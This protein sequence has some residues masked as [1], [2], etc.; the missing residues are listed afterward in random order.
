M[1]RQ[2]DNVEIQGQQP[3][4]IFYTVVHSVR[5]VC[6]F[7]KGLV[8]YLRIEDRRLSRIVNSTGSML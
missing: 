8:L 4:R 7:L 5:L 6:A 3:D 2:A 1:N